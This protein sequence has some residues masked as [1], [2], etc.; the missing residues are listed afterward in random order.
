MIRQGDGPRHPATPASDAPERLP[1]RAD[2]MERN[3]SGLA[4][5]SGTGHWPSAGTVAM[6]PNRHHPSRPRLPSVMDRGP[7]IED[8]APTRPGLW[9]V[10]DDRKVRRGVTGRVCRLRPDS[11]QPVDTGPPNHTGPSHG[12]SARLGLSSRFYVTFPP[13]GLP[14]RDW[15]RLVPGAPDRPSRRRVG[16]ATP[17]KLGRTRGRSSRACLPHKFVL[18]LTVRV[19]APPFL[20]RRS[21][22]A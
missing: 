14:G 4:T 3:G 21:P 2:A 5:R 8:T 17:V 18:K 15:L 9:K 6:D 16:D 20:P 1:R 22:S 19:P 7:G 12:I 11:I 10:V 13:D